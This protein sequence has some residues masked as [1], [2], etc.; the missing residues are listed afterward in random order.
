M[1]I[2]V[3]SID[4]SLSNE[5][6]VEAEGRTWWYK[7][8]AE[9][10][11]APRFEGDQVE[12]DIVEFDHDPTIAEVNAIYI[13]GW[14][15]DL[16]AVARYMATKPE[17]ADDRYIAIQWGVRPDGTVACAIWMR[18]VSNRK[19]VILRDGVRWYRKCRFARVRKVSSGV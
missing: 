7:N 1:S 6:A 16:V 3:T 19:V 9:L 18:G 13:D 17:A 12:I 8:Q 14:V 5:Q 10:D 15:P 11:A 4:R 2:L